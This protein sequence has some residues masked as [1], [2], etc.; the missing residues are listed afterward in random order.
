MILDIFDKKV[1][2]SKPTRIKGTPNA[3]LL[4]QDPVAIDYEGKE[5]IIEA[6]RAYRGL[7]PIYA[8][9]ILVLTPPKMLV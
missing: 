8:P 6:E 2:K 1:K 5:Q 3:I 7:S 4:S 9:L